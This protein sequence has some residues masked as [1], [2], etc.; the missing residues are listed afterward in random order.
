[1]RFLIVVLVLLTIPAQAQ[2]F[3]WPTE[4]KNLQVLDGVAGD[5]LGEVMRGFTVSLGVRCAHCHVGEEGQPLTTFDFASDAKPN[6][7]ITREMI[8]MM[9][10]IDAVMESVQEPA[11]PKATVGCVNCHLG[12]TKPEDPA[13]LADELRKQRARGGR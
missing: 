3:E 8:R 7:E 13:T 5:E 9:W 6:K 2:R 11:E 4:P 1:M 10:G 12:R